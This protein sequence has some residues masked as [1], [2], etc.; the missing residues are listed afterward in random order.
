MSDIADFPDFSSVIKREKCGWCKDGDHTNHSAVDGGA[1]EVAIKEVK[2]AGYLYNILC[3]CKPLSPEKRGICLSCLSGQCEHTH[4]LWGNGVAECRN[5]VRRTTV[6][7]VRF[8]KL[9]G[10]TYRT[11]HG[12]TKGVPK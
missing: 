2:V 11:G 12:K 5:T 10:C 7:G 1:C 8:N 9:C 6:L 3:S 4:T